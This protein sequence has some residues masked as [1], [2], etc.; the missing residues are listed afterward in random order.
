MDDSTTEPVLF[1]GWFAKPLMARFDQPDSSSDAGAVLVRGLDDRLGLT[2]SMAD[3]L[4]DGRAAGR[5]QH[6]LVDVLR[7]RVYGIACGYED[8][9]D[10]ARLRHDPI[11]KLLLDR[12]PLM[13]A[14]LASQ[15][16]IS[17][18]ENVVDALEL[19]G[20]ALALAERVIARHRRRLG[21]AVKRITI[22]LDG[23]ADPVHGQ[24]QGALFNG[25]YGIHCYLPLLG[26]LQFDRESEQYLFAA[27]LRRGTARAW[28][29]AEVVLRRLLP[30]LRSVFPKARLRVRLDGGFAHPRILNFLDEQR[31]EYV[32]GFQANK[33]LDRLV[34]PTLERSRA[35]SRSSGTSERRY[36]DATYRAESWPRARR[37]V[38][39]AEVTRFGARDPR[40]NPRFVIT[41]LES[42]PKAV[43][44]RVYVQ[45][46]DI[47]NRIKEL[48]HGIDMGR[49]SCS[50]FRANQTRLL[51]HAAA[52]VLYQELRLHARGT[53]L[54]SAQV[55][56][57]RDRL[58]KLGGWIERTKRRITL[59]LPSD[60]PWRHEWTRIAHSLQ[61]AT[62]A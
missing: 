62:S 21:K 43:Y 60:A 37:V 22:D 52:Y 55:A 31:L 29:G 18:F 3:A 32:V 28:V 15:P 39:K 49:T 35:A 46:G 61:T 50:S 27:V 41:N 48:H 58:I 8:G 26:F 9:N 47:E 11:Q 44:Q 24:Q 5:V 42:P 14:A 17:R 40:D 2:S 33:V 16:T 57:L 10:A 30:R 34:E 54:A 45:R 59:H 19:K 6:S 51:L 20:M 53:D 4:D 36:G 12:D 25:Y 1:D 38:F 56:T 23:S 7:Q 13:G